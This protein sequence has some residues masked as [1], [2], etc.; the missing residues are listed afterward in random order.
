MTIPLFINCRDR[1]DTVVA[2][3]EWAQR[4]PNVA[5]YLVD[6]ASTF[7]PLLDYYR[8][9]ATAVLFA[10]ENGGPRT[11][12]RFIRE[13]LNGQ[14]FY[15]VTDCDLDM[16][17]VPTDVVQVC[18]QALL[19]C[20]T[21]VKV[22]CALSLDGLPADHIARSRESEYWADDKRHDI[23]IDGRAIPAYE[24]LID[25]TFAVYD[26]TRPLGGFYGPA[27]R[28]AGDYTCRHRPWHYSVDRLPV[29]ERYYLD[30]LDPAGIFYSN[31]LKAESEER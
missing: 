13:R 23:A 26:T 1:L 8:R 29:D 24:S 21:L 4:L 12:W 25:T 15:V 22:G 31:L 28:L 11:P 20:P 2:M 10:G 18:S 7:P 6:N 19:D 14:Q 30:H 5:V 27:L 3:V 9:T 16:T 17:S